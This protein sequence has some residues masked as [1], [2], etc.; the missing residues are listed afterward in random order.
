[1]K[2]IC[3]RCGIRLSPNFNSSHFS[4][5]RPFTEASIEQIIP[6]EK[7]LSV[8]NLSEL[9]RLA[10]DCY[11]LNASSRTFDMAMCQFFA[12]KIERAMSLSRKLNTNS[13]FLLLSYAQATYFLE[14][15]LASL[16]ARMVQERQ[17]HSAPYQQMVKASKNAE[18]QFDLYLLIM[19]RIFRVGR[20]D[21]LYEE[22]EKM[23]KNF[24]SK[25]LYV[26]ASVWQNSPGFYS[27][28]IIFLL[29]I[30]ILMRK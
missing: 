9:H 29:F 12:Q 22:A 1:M 4:L 26:M 17:E 13:Y 6:T 10:E 15:Q 20:D 21:A 19:D 27:L 11:K 28:W 23:R 14:E 18:G 24:Y 25:F 7:V 2:Q 5:D 3:D 30:F 16:R 8:V